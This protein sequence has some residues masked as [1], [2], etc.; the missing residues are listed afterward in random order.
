MQKY[1][2]IKDLDF[3]I[4][5]LVEMGNEVELVEINGPNVTIDLL[6]GAFSNLRTTQ[7]ITLEQFNECFE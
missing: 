5:G 3:G 7:I 2:A 4:S 6:D 1:K